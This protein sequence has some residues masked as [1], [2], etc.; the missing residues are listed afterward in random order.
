MQLSHIGHEKASL[1]DF[2]HIK[3]D[4]EKL[5]QEFDTAPK[6]KD[7]NSMKLQQEAVID[8]LKK[9]LSLSVTLKELGP[10]LDQKVNISDMN[11]TLQVIQNEVERCVREDDLK[12]SLNEQALV[13]EALCAENC[14]A[15]WIWKS[16][17][18]A[19]K[20]QIPWEL[21]TI[22]TC[23]DNFLWEKGKPSIICAAPGLY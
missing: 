21:Q 19:S 4:M 17:D 23:P 22:N 6:H 2:R 10:L 9:T 12:K 16:G 5:R 18:L 20:N 11:S 15:R 8:D 14:V 7:L 13:N 3:A 1:E